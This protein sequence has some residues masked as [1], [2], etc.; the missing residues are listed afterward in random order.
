MQWRQIRRRHSSAQQQ[1]TGLRRV[2][3]EEE[4]RAKK[5]HQPVR[6]NVRT[7]TRSTSHKLPVKGL[8]D[9][10][11]LAL[12]VDAVFLEALRRYR[13]AT[14]GDRNEVDFGPD[15]PQADAVSHSDWAAKEGLGKARGYLNQRPSEPDVRAREGA[16]IPLGW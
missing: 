15:D 2:G 12:D 10:D 9:E 13:E 4:A 1:P 7:S 14:L 3:T 8:S 16:K 5:S 11:V 6:A